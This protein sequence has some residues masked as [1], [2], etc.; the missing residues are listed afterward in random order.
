MNFKKKPYYDSWEL[1]VKPSA[2]KK[3]TIIQKNNLFLNTGEKNCLFQS[4]Q[5]SAGILLV[6][7]IKALHVDY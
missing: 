3:R 4:S 6:S 7:T 1:S 2:N 5:Q